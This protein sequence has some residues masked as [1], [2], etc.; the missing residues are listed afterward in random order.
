M[1]CRSDRLQR[2]LAPRRLNSP[3]CVTGSSFIGDPGA[4]ITYSP[5]F[6]GG[7][8]STTV[9]T[10]ADIGFGEGEPVAGTITV[11]GMINGPPG[12]LS[13]GAS[14]DTDEWVEAIPVGHGIYDQNLQGGGL[15]EFENAS[16]A[17]IAG[18]N[19]VGGSISAT[20][21]DSTLYI[22]F[23]VASTVET[24]DGPEVGPVV[25]Y[26]VLLGSTSSPVSLSTINPL[27]SPYMMGA[28]P[29]FNH[30]TLDFTATY[31]ATPYTPSSGTSAS[32]NSR[33]G[34]CW[35]SA[36]RG[37]GWRAG[38]VG[39]RRPTARQ[40]LRLR[41]R[42]RRSAD[43]RRRLGGKLPFC[44]KSEAAMR[45]GPFRMILRA[46]PAILAAAIGF[47]INAQSARALSGAPASRSRA[48]PARPFCLTSIRTRSRRPSPPV[49]TPGPRLTA[50]RAFS[51]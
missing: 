29:Y 7:Y 18:G 45:A 34:R 28:C 24:P 43:Q 48:I 30:F 36:S 10:G 17:V 23:D 26:L 50:A 15:F 39:Q 8:F 1:H 42:S 40:T 44:F 41:G 22:Q 6:F 16:G 21:G 38:S 5:D 25:G 33:P 46:A 20:P 35:R 12:F 2:R 9:Y 31:Q 47:T 51:L 32:R 49:S 11:P 14:A 37:W 4:T 27:C 3:S 13:L 19:L